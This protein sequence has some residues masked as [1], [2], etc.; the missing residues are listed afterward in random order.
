MMSHAGARYFSLSTHFRSERFRA[1]MI[2]G[3]GAMN[4]QRHRPE[5]A[6][7]EAGM[8]RRSRIDFLRAERD[9]ET[10]PRSPPSLRLIALFTVRE[11]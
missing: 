1:E 8:R 7:K 3:E 5:P 11:S 10:M 6:V 2:E 9:D 4:T